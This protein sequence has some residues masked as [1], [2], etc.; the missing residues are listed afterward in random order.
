M[1]RSKLVTAGFAS[2]LGVCCGVLLTGVD[3][4]IEPLFRV[5]VLYAPAIVVNTVLGMLD[6]GART[7]LSVASA[8]GFTAILFLLVAI[9]LW[10]GGRE[11]RD[12]WGA[13]IVIT[14]SVSFIYTVLLTG[15]ALPA[16][17]VAGGVFAGV[18]IDPGHAIR[19]GAPEK[20]RRR[21]FLRTVA[22][23][24][25]AV[26]PIGA[27][28]R[29]RNRD[30]PPIDAV[31]L[32][33]TAQ[34]DVSELLEQ[35][36]A[37]SFSL[38]GSPDLIS[39]IGEFYTVDINRRPPVVDR[40]QWT[41]SITGAVEQSLTVTFDEL[42]TEPL[43][44]A[45]ATL[46]CIGDTLNGPLMDTAVWTGVELASLL[47]RAG[48]VGEH[49]VVRGADG[50]FERLPQETL[51]TAIVA[52]AMNGE[53]L[54]RAHGYPARLVIPGSWG[55]INTKWVTEIEILAEPGD[56]YW[57]NRGWNGTAPMQIVAKL[58]SIDSDGDTIRIGGHAYGG[59]TG[60]SRVEV[61]TDGGHRW[62][63]ANLSAPVTDDD[64][65]SRQWEYSFTRTDDTHEVVVRAYDRSGNRQEQPTADAFPD[66]P[67][68]W[69]TVEL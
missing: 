65:V 30:P 47:D 18:L 3:G 40:D 35:A 46:R 69:V 63:D 31:D 23:T 25:A 27:F 59:D 22:G 20:D 67:T 58:W 41:L 29:Y 14:L 33:G 4:L 19:R 37:R 61:S 36:H 39:D 44:T 16:V 26:L 13:A 49:A 21:R 32:P 51:E 43:L 48:V 8:V 10:A 1:D 60:I 5:A 28:G 56:G 38:P 15:R 62:D 50:Y 68:G 11:R 6:S 7:L 34:S 17:G 45:P 57:T 55:K 12:P 64:A 2:L 66:G 42:V 54:P 53:T 9:S 52:V 24:A